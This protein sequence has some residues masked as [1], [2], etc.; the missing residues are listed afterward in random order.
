MI[1]N[2][3]NKNAIDAKFFGDLDINSHMYLKHGDI[4]PEER[5]KHIHKAKNWTDFLDT[6]KYMTKTKGFVYCKICVLRIFI[7]EEADLNKQ[8]KI[9]IHHLTDHSFIKDEHKMEYFEIRRK[10]SKPRKTGLA[11]WLGNDT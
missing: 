1:W 4:A 5:Q 7:C 11:K 3:R 2:Q 9:D 6:R 10:K 8:K